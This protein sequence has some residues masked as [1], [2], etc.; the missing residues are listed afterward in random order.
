MGLHGERSSF[1]ILPP[2]NIPFPFL[3][4]SS[5]SN[6]GESLQQA[7]EV[8]LKREFELDMAMEMDAKELR[9]AVKFVCT[10]FAQRFFG[11]K[12]KKY[13]CSFLP[14][15]PATTSVPSGSDGVGRPVCVITGATSGLG[16]ATAYALS[17]EGFYIVLAGRS[18]ESLSKA[19]SNIKR[20]NTGAYVKAFQVDISSFKSILKFKSSLQQWLLD[21][22][23]H[24]SIQL[25]INNAGVLATSARLS[26]EEYDQYSLLS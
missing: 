22:D 13:V 15:L 7:G 23:M 12:A 1:T 26:A 11:Q 6:F 17:M 2:S 16:A 24:S 18:S 25:L 5:N 20:Q 4:F 10:L 14:L 19:V 9:E 8:L 21:S 3:F